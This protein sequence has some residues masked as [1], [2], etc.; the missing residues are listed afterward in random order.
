MIGRKYVGHVTCFSSGAMLARC[1]QS[2]FPIICAIELVPVP[3]AAQQTTL[4][5]TGTSADSRA[6][7]SAPRSP[8]LAHLPPRTKE[9]P[10]PIPEIPPD[11]ADSETLNESPHAPST[12]SERIYFGDRPFQIES[13]LGI[14]TSVG[15]VGAVAEYNLL[16]RA[17]VGAGVGANIWG[18][19]VGAHL[20][21]RPIAGATSSGQRL[22]ALTLESAL[23]VG[24]FAGMGSYIP[25]MNSCDEYDTSGCS[26]KYSAEWT[27]WFQAE[28]GWETR[29]SNGLSLRISSG[30]AWAL[31]SP[32]RKCTVLGK[33]V[34]CGGSIEGLI[35][36]F[37]FALGYAW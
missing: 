14:S 37:T 22:H 11:E 29:A 34:A 18:P 12:Q 9:E 26:T 16:E 4:E 33:A 23:S 24:R 35:P 8:I 2:V 31:Y 36:T 25:S 7:L 32:S 3:L 27:A 1:L 6:E 20:R 5:Q 21:L 13:R 30:Y 19:E 28:L 17:A 15:E 10:G